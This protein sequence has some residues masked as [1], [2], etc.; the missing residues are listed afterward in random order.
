MTDQTEDDYAMMQQMRLWDSKLSKCP[1]EMLVYIQQRAWSILEH[2]T[3]LLN[4]QT[5]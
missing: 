1:I 3:E 5:N 2:R 4:N